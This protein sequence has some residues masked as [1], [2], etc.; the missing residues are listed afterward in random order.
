MADEELIPQGQWGA[1]L[2][3]SELA[4]M[5]SKTS[6]FANR[7]YV[8]PYG[9]MVRITFGEMVEGTTNWHS[10]IV[11]SGEDLMSFIVLFA[12]QAAWALSGPES[13]AAPAAKEPPPQEQKDGGQ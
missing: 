11:V 1:G 13:Q 4:Q 7:V 5:Q 9:S 6:L 8:R 10:S 3:P 2:T 12:E